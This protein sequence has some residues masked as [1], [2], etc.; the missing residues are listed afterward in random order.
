M[1]GKKTS[2]KIKTIVKGVSAA[3][4][5]TFFQKVEILQENLGN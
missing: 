5:E 4:P 1:S 2:T 3:L